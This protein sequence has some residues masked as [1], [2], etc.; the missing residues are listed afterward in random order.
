M[1]HHLSKDCHPIVTKSC[2]C[3]HDDNNFTDSKVKCLLLENIIEPTNSPGRAQVVI[4]AS[5][6]VKKRLCNDLKSPYQEILLLI[7]DKIYTAFETN[8]KLYQFTRIPFG[9]TNATFQQKMG[10]F[11]VEK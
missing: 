1:Q 8:G 2:D 10:N 9:L 4:M 3:S 11:I 5:E 7:K 6:N